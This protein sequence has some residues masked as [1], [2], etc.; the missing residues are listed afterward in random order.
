M[1]YE[2]YSEKEFD[3]LKDCDIITYYNNGDIPFTDRYKE[4]IKELI[5]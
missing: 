1:V 2:I 5:L 3:K 4:K